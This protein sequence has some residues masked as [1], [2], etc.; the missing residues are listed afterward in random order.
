MCRSCIIMIL[1]LTCAAIS[2]ASGMAV[3]L[4]GPWNFALDRDNTGMEQGWFNRPLAGSETIALPGS[5]QIRGYG[6][7]PSANTKW[8]L[9]I[10]KDLLNMPQF[11]SYIQADDFKCPFWLTPA[12]VYVGLAWYQRKISLPANWPA[13]QTAELFLERAHWQTTIWLDGRKMG[14]CDSLGT[15]HRYILQDKNN[16]PLEPGK[17]YLL[18]ICV[19]NRVIVNVGLDAHSISDQTQG[20]WNGII[21]QIELRPAGSIHIENLQVY[22]RPDA[23]K[24]NLRVTLSD[25][26]EI[27]C[28]LLVEASE[29]S[30]GRK[31]PP[32]QYALYLPESLLEYEI[33]QAK[34]WNEFD[35]QLYDLNISLVQLPAKE[36]L[37]TAAT[38]FGMRQL[39]I[40]GT[41]FTINGCHIFLRGTLECCIFPDTGYPP[42]DLASWKRI[43]KIARAHGLNHLRFH[44][45]CPPQAAFDAA[46]EMGFYYQVDVSCWAVLGHD[47]LQ[48]SWVYQETI[49]MINEYGNH[50]SF[51]LLTPSNEPHGDVSLRDAYLADWIRYFEQFDERRF[52]CAGANWPMIEAN[53]YHN[54]SKPRQQNYLDR[55]P[56]TAADYSDFIGQQNKPVISHEIGQWCAYPDFAEVEQYRGFMQPGNIEIFH[57]MLVKAGLGQLSSAFVTATGKFQALLYKREIEAALSTAGMAGFQLLDLHDFPGQGTA[58]VGILNAYWE[59]KGYITP[60]QYRRFCNDIVPLARMNKLVY[61]NNENLTA[62]LEICHFGPEPLTN[63]IVNWQL[64]D[65]ENIIAQGQLSQEQ[66]SAGKLN[67][68]GQI[69]ID[70]SCVKQA[71]QLKLQVELAGTDYAN[72]W[73]IWV[74]PAVV[75]VADTA[76]ILITQNLD[77]DFM[78]KV[79]N[80]GKILFIPDP[81]ALKVNTCGSFKPVFWNR[82]T[83]PGRDIH[84][85]GTLCD[86]RHP[87]LSNFPT[88]SFTNF[89]WWE[90]LNKSKPLILTDLAETIN[91]I[92]RVIDDWT[93]CRSLG[94]IFEVK[95]GKADILICSI[96]IANDL[97]NRPVARQLKY[98]L[99]KYMNSD[100]FTPAVDISTDSLKALYIE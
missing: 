52:Y 63:A 47:R 31:L 34:L 2:Q 42:T 4:S 5:L 39:G 53:N 100:K 76:N 70:L 84:T 77:T 8:T 43:L 89:Q 64:T 23:G 21:G 25:M 78:T 58:P 28:Q 14:S 9:N 45:W 65:S 56:Q 92:V 67:P 30:S 13:G 57:D 54:P 17:E 18:T 81:Q 72:D 48:D 74:Y 99:L 75:P 51:I 68:V 24:I 49:R 85:L 59:E 37:D 36:V 1:V 62:G 16:S 44:A 86:P 61:L 29:R 20:N 50:P 95:A 94:L 79:H 91:P 73:D 40:E 83:F 80:G 66:L 98:S 71:S 3:D 6:D 93:E 55:P 46:D 32:R 22:P 35:P 33:P 82:I 7:K 11:Q 19:D 15:P 10:G 88:D 97:D 87:A 60:A 69:S 12:R 27:K 38:T 90:L 96:D 26:P 41:Q